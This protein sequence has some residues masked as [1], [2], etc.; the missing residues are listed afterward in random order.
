MH[1]ETSDEGSESCMKAQDPVMK[2]Q[3]PYGKV[4]QHVYGIPS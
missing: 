1:M 2:A 4:L 3:D